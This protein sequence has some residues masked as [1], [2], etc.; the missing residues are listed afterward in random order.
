MALVKTNKI[1]RE[2]SPLGGETDH[3]QRRREKNQVKQQKA[4]DKIASDTQD[5]AAGVSEAASAIEELQR[6]MEQISSG[7]QEASRAAEISKNAITSASTRLEDSET[8]AKVSLTRTTELQTSISELATQVRESID[9]IQTNA[10]RQTQSVN[11][12]VELEKQAEAIGDI[13]N[14]VARIADQTNLLALNAAIEAAR[15]GQ[16]GKGFA[17]VADEVRT[18]AENSEK[19]AEEIEKLVKTIQTQ[20][21]EIG[22]SIRLS[23][24]KASSETEQGRE[25]VERL[26]ETTERMSEIADAAQVMQTGAL[27][28]SQSAIRAQSSSETISVAAEEQAA[29]VEEALRT[30]EQQTTS[31]A[32]CDASTGA[33][34]ELVEELRT[35]SDI[36][37]QADRVTGAAE[38]LSSAVEEIHRSAT[39]IQTA[40]SQIEQ[41]AADQ[42]KASHESGTALEDIEKTSQVTRDRAL[43]SLELAKDIQA[44]LVDNRSRIES[45]VGGVEQSLQVTSENRERMKDLE[46]RSREIDKIVDAITTVSIQTNML[47]V[48]GSVEAARAGEF[49]KGFAVVSTDIRNL[50]Q[51][52]AENADRIKDLVKAIQEQVAMVR[53]DL[54][55]TVAVGQLEVKKNETITK[56]LIEVAEA[57]GQAVDDNQSISENTE[58]IL[59]EVQ[60]V[61]SGVD[62]IAAAAE[63]S[64]RSAN[65]AAVASGQQEKSARLLASTIEN[66][67]SMAEELQAS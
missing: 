30:I 44:I 31:I 41:G 6:A 35:S 24:E 19:S 38:E 39:Q 33:L 27:G 12:I 50:A 43:S 37:R 49:G 7:A 14:A 66:I 58:I 29:A 59:K 45:L 21:T 18:L 10:E 60:D 5:L 28:A 57:M 1:S 54:G 9:N 63:E 56:K 51:E 22:E 53:I 42:A 55:E 62:E 17:V 26:A 11:I 8:K 23:A 15:A 3:G 65:E 46:K 13:V 40:L 36:S 47:A 4:A 67:A 52:S 2:D 61:K 20:V 32:E 16:H 64:S 34:S 48:N 25:A